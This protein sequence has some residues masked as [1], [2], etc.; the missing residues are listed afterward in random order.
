[1]KEIKKERTIT[2]TY[3]EY[4]AIDGEIFKTKEECEKYDNSAMAVVQQKYNKLILKKDLNEYDVFFGCG[5]EDNPVEIIKV[6]S[7]DDADLVK[8]L[9]LLANPYYK[10]KDLPD[11]MKEDFKQIEEA[12]RDKDVLFIGRGYDHDSFWV[13][14]SS[15][16]LCSKINEY[17]KLLNTKPES[18]LEPEYGGC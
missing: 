16:L 1:M 17:K 18:K 11:W 13:Y 9:C 12:V 2:E 6:E 5:C 15:K 10:D 3:Y 14:G 7:K 8:Q 4:E